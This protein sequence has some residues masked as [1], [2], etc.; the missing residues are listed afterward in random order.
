MDIKQLK[1]FLDLYETGNFTK[2]AENLF[3]SQQALSSSILT[4][5]RELGR[6]LFERTPNGIVP[7]AAGDILRDLSIPL[8]RNFDEMTLELGARF[9]RIKEP[10]FLGL[11]P[12]VL[13]ACS[14][15]M[16]FR[17]RE[18]NQDIELKGIESSDTACVENV[19]NGTADIALCPR[20]HDITDME[21]IPVGEEKIYAVVNR[22]SP[23]AGRGSVSVADLRNEKL[24]SLNKYYEVY[25]KLVECCRR[26]GFTPEFIVESGESGILLSMVKM[27]MCVFVCMEYITRDM[28]MEHCLKIPLADEDMVWKYGLVRRRGR[29]LSHATDRFIDFI[30]HH[31]SRS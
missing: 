7:T 14:P 29:P 31:T 3:L 5:E 8:V 19:I 30:V 20:P 16:L 2:T 24:V 11:A 12:G 18:A 4:L 23:L 13:Q 22:E 1:R 28:D 9:E 25:H 17:F 27:N 10:L 21:Y 26:H 6:A 15:D